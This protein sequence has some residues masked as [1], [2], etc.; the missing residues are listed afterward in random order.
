ADG[1]PTATV[2]LRSPA[3]E[4]VPLRVEVAADE[5]ARRRGLMGRRSLPPGAG[6]LFVYPG[7]HRGGFWM[8]D[9]RIPLTI[10]FSTATGGSC[11]CS[12]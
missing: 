11:A 2:V 8:R 7:P 12:T 4:R 10:A 3:G 5:A 6:M 1:M 9:T